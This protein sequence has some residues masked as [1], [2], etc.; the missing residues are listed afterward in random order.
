M[1]R[2]CISERAGGGRVAIRVLTYLSP[3]RK[4]SHAWG[5]AWECNGMGRLSVH[6]RIL[7]R[8][9]VGERTQEQ[10]VGHGSESRASVVAARKHDEEEAG[11]LETSMLGEVAFLD[12]V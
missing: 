1:G 2:I 12:Q 10:E 4:T 8:P 7:G 11:Q 6:G 5:H 9:A 3:D